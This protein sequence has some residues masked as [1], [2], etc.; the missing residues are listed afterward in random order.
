[1]WALFC[2]DSQVSQSYPSRQD[3][4]RHAVENDLVDDGD[5]VENYQIKEVAG[6]ADA[7]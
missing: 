4:W 3:V 6:V 5:L 1:M 2:E 7:A